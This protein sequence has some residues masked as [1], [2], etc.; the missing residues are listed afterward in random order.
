MMNSRQLSALTPALLFVVFAAGIFG[1]LATGSE[2]L[3]ATGA[4][5]PTDI[6]IPSSS[7]TEESA[8]ASQP[9]SMSSGDLSQTHLQADLNSD[10]AMTELSLAKEVAQA[11]IAPTKPA[12]VQ[13]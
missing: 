4:A 10:A 11:P 12:S 1:L 2:G 13:L 7:T 5:T 3:Q 8:T 6:G 9:S